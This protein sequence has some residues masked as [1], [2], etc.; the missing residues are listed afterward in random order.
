MARHS[1]SWII[2]KASGY[3]CDTECRTTLG[4]SRLTPWDAI[5]RPC[6]G[7]DRRDSIVDDAKRMRTVAVGLSK[8]RE[9]DERVVPFAASDARAFA[10]SVKRRGP[11]V[12]ITD[13]DA[14]ISTVQQALAGFAQ[15]PS[16]AVFFLVTRA[17]AR[18]GD[19]WLSL[20]DG[21]VSLTE[22]LRSAWDGPA[23]RL[24]VLLDVMREASENDRPTADD[25][26]ACLPA[27]T[28]RALL[29]ADDGRNGSHISGELQSGIWAHHVA[30]AFS[31]NVVAAQ[32]RDGSLTGALL[33]RY[34]ATEV[35]RSL[36]VAYRARR[37]QS[38]LI[39]APSDDLVLVDAA[40][41]NAP[42]ASAD[43][44]PLFG[45]RFFSEQDVM[46]KT[47]G[48]F[49]KSV[50]SVPSDTSASSREWV[51]RLAEPDLAKELEVT[52][53]RLREHLRYKRRDVRVD[54][55]AEGAASILTPDFSYHLT[56]RQHESR[57]DRAV[58]RR[59]LSEINNLKMLGRSELSHAFPA[60]FV[61]LA[62]SFD[63]PADVEVLVD[64]LEDAEPPAIAKLDY[65]TDLAFCTIKLVGFEGAVRIDREGLTVSGPGPMS[66]AE[67]AAQFALAKSL[68]KQAH[69]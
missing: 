3:V 26:A 33:R 28:G 13:A 48:G 60:G 21:V 58:F 22:L 18:D 43:M 56:A 25:V 62:Q 29:L 49:R 39:L 32:A 1:V 46:V 11:S 17:V 4:I 52:V 53:A 65:P 14:T 63:Q 54:G 51:A 42:Q 61:S 24:I 44:P 8:F 15:H 31:G 40:H 6:R 38:P 7:S 68:L 64:A 36:G 37:E 47:L 57:P 67:L 69:A 45:V 41:E 16:D 50:H 66:P 35:P 9:G 55:P 10:E 27:R 12:A 23:S 20:Y 34:L 5:F 19:V 30:Q 2:G 59:S